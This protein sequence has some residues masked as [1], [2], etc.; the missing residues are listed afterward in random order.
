M[1][2]GK[3]ALEKFTAQEVKRLNSLGDSLRTKLTE[4]FSRAKVKAQVA[5]AG[6]IFRIHLISDP[7]IDYRS[8]FLY[9]ERKNLWFYDL[10]SGFAYVRMS[11]DSNPN[12][13][14]ISGIYRLFYSNAPL[15][16]PFDLLS[17]GDVHYEG[18][19]SS[20]SPITKQLDNETT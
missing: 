9:P 7:L 13:K 10:E 4:L 11:D 19:L 15:D 3:A 12:T 16:L 6:S 18:A 8:T 17:G 2:A 14:S 5:G 1:V 20:N